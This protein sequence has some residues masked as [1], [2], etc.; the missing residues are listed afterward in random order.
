MKWLTRSY[1]T[2]PFVLPKNLG[3]CYWAWLLAV[4]CRAGAG[5]SGCVV[6]VR[7]TSPAHCLAPSV[8]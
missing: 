7:R 5:L 3:L 6:C 2:V 4:S 8:L 1:G